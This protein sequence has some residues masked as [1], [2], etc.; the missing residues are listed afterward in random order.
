MIRKRDAWFAR[1]VAPALNNNNIQM[2]KSVILGTCSIVRNFLTLILLTWWI[3]WAPNNASKGQMGF[4][5]AFKW[6]TTNKTTE[7]NLFDYYIPG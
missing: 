7:P 3:W 2:Q 5:S 6:L 4:N 1:D